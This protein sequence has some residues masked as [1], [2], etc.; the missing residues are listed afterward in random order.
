[1]NQEKLLKKS[2]SN[3]N[4]TLANISHRDRDRIRTQLTPAQIYKIIVSKY[5]ILFSLGVF[6]IQD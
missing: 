6:F 3:N 5:S 1:M 4:L 2:T